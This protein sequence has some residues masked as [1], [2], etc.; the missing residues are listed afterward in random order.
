MPRS[1]SISIVNTRELEMLEPCLTSLFENP[2]TGGP[3]EVI[4]LNNASRAGSAEPIKERFPTVRVVE[5]AQW[6]GFGANHNRVARLA[7]GELLFLLNPDA[8]VHEGA[9]DRLAHALT[10]NPGAAVAA[11]SILNPDGSVM[12]DSPFIFPSPAQSLAQ[13]VGFHRLVNSDH[14]ADG[15]KTVFDGWVSGSAFMIDRSVFLRSG[16]FDER[17]FIYSEETDLMLRLAE[18]GWGIAWVPD[19]RVTHIG[20]SLLKEETEDSEGTLTRLN[21]Y[22]LRRV[23]QFVLSNVYYMQKHRGR[24]AALGYRAALGLDSLLRLALAAIPPLRRLL[25]TKGPNAA[26]TRHHHLTRFRAAI[27]PT[28]G[29]FLSDLAEEWN[30][31]LCE[32]VGR[33]ERNSPRSVD[34]E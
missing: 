1:L 7:K 12:Q 24:G 20:R 18:S 34:E 3:S 6:R 9:L 4:V 14:R 29:P 13:A 16:G 27:N 28:R 22:E 26:V 32:P 31:A 17:F 5:E 8:Q 30:R 15:Q 25:D 11:G 2:Y 21:D 23:N 10:A 33:G 19:A